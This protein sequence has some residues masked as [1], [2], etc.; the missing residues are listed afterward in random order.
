[1]HANASFCHV[2]KICQLRLLNENYSKKFEIYCDEMK[3][4]KVRGNFALEVIQRRIA[5]A[6]VKDDATIS[7]RA[8]RP[9]SIVIAGD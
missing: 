2:Y 1:M 5:L 4:Y 8:T 3:H 9:L 7:F 6:D